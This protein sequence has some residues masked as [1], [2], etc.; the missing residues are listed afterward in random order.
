MEKVDLDIDVLEKRV[1]EIS[2]GML[3]KFLIATA[4]A[5]EPDLV[6]LDEPT[7]SLDNK[8]K[9]KIIDL[10]KNLYKEG[11]TFVI[12]T[13][14]FSFAKE[15]A[16]HILVLYNGWAAEYGKSDKL[17]QN[18]RHPYSKGLLGSCPQINLFRD[19]WGIRPEDEAKNSLYG[20]KF[21]LRCNQRICDCANICP[22][23]E[24]H[25]NEEERLI[26][27]IRGGIVKVLEGRQISKAFGKSD[28]I[29]GMDISV[30]SSEIVGIFG[31]SGIGKTTL[32][33]I[34]SGLMKL[35]DGEVLNNITGPKYILK[36]GFYS[37]KSNN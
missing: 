7:S 13:H 10:I 6:I 22:T 9:E 24:E 17:I 37:I 28:I 19:S 29:K 20:C 4:I 30:F 5:L 15:V 1:N 23:L 31:A 16:S 33:K 27:C 36:S 26:S 11:A 2:G 14:D 3:Q 8:S 12:V 25:D 21:Y 35:E 34:L 32:I 18:P